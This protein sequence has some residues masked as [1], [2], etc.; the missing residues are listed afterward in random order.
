MVILCVFIYN[1]LCKS[2]SEFFKT[3][4]FDPYTFVKVRAKANLDISNILTELNSLLPQLSNFIQQFNDVV[5]QTGINVVTDTHGNMSITAPD[6][7]S[8]SMLNETSVRIG[9]IDRL[10]TTRGQEI[11]DLLV[12]GLSIEEKLK[13]RDPGYTSQLSEKIEEFKRLNTNYKH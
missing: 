10:I 3:E 2:K 8:D 13:V 12:K 9:V 6:N 11:N 1:F 7:I 5:N 4:V